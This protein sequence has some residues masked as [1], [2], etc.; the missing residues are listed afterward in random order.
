MNKLEK[1]A[2]KAG[3]QRYDLVSPI[4]LPV[5]A[6]VLT[7]CGK[8]KEQG[9]K[10]YAPH[11]WL[12][13]TSMVDLLAAAERHLTKFKLGQ[14]TDEETGLP[15]VDLAFTNLMMLVH[16]YHLNDFQKYDDR[17]ALGVDKDFSLLDEVLK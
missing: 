9:G 2:R 10:G 5:L 6:R 17:G 13:T 7:H 8:P 4:T 15:H 3:K 14:D 16:M 12:K 11:D 1:D